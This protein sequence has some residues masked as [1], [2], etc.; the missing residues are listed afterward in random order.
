MPLAAQIRQAM[1]WPVPMLMPHTIIAAMFGYFA[2]AMPELQDGTEDLHQLSLIMPFVY[3]NLLHCAAV[4]ALVVA[5]RLSIGSF[6]QPIETQVL[7]TDVLWYFTWRVIF[8]LTQTHGDNALLWLI[9]LAVYC[10]SDM[11]CNLLATRLKHTP[12]T[13]RYPNRVHVSIGV[14]LLLVMTI[15]LSSIWTL[16]SWSWSGVCEPTVAIT[17]FIIVGVKTMQGIGGL[18]TMYRALVLPESVVTLRGQSAMGLYNTFELVKEALYCLL[19][20]LLVAY[21]AFFMNIYSSGLSLS[22]SPGSLITALLLRQSIQRFGKLRQQRRNYRTVL[23]SLSERC[24]VATAEE[25]RELQDNC[26]ICW[27]EFSAETAGVQKLPCGHYFHTACLISWMEHDITCPT[28]R[29]SLLDNQPGSQRAIGQNRPGP[30]AQQPPNRPL[31]DVVRHRPLVTAAAEEP[32]AA[33]AGDGRQATQQ[34]EQDDAGDN[35]I[36]AAADVIPTE[37]DV[38]AA[39]FNYIRNNGVEVG[40][41]DAA[42]EDTIDGGGDVTAA[43]A[44]A[45]AGAGHQNMPQ[46]QQHGPAGTGAHTAVPAPPAPPQNQRRGRTFI[47]EGALSLRFL[48]R[49]NIGLICTLN[50]DPSQRIIVQTD[51]DAA[52]AAPRPPGAGGNVNPAAAAGAEHVHRRR[53]HQHR[54]HHHNHPHQP[55]AP[56]GTAGH[57]HHHRHPHPHHHHGQPRAE[58]SAATAAAA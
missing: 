4:W 41:D 16:F 52:A 54:H 43:H 3:I 51:A 6:L 20:A 25:L 7:H 55:L 46:Q 28:C 56:T 11:F 23:T 10:Y 45:S 40:R 33:G 29:T 12:Q 44:A 37:E 2:G 22:V 49:I 18:W 35:I 50:G 31:F 17:M 34:A 5:W 42:A 19:Y 8:F 13:S 15:V 27:E 21:L 14:G 1:A 58:A 47:L 48:P 24:R 39:D 30:G 38:M 26:A 9:H 53:R 36:A 32:A 57:Q